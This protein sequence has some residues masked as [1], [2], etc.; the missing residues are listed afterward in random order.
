MTSVGIRVFKLERSSTVVSE[1]SL[2][3]HLASMFVTEL[4][5]LLG[6]L[7]ASDRSITPGF[8]NLKS[9]DRYRIYRILY[10]QVQSQQ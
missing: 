9:G 6:F 2:C 1:T 10:M 8:A 3:L 7:A 4:S 5:Q